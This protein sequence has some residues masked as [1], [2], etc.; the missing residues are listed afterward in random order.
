MEMPNEETHILPDSFSK[1]QLKSK[2]TNGPTIVYN[3]NTIPCDS[4][5]LLNQQ[6]NHHVSNNKI[7]FIPFLLEHTSDQWSHLDQQ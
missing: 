7:N 6:S 5:T 3:K 1:L 2:L 4:L